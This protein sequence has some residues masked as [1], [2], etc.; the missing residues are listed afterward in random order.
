MTTGPI[1]NYKG[2][3]HAMKS[4]SAAK[5]ADYTATLRTLLVCGSHRNALGLF[6]FRN[7][8]FVIA[9]LFMQELILRWVSQGEK[10]VLV[11]LL[12]VKLKLQIEHH[13]VLFFNPLRAIIVF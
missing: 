11:M 3:H 8:R 6:S 12:S 10:G 13:H 7:D 9:H 4:R 5:R 2:Y 1:I